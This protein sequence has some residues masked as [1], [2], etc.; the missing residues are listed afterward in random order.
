V[1][2][3]DPI[4]L[5][6]DE[7]PVRAGVERANAQLDSYGRAGTKAN[8]DVG[9]SAEKAAKQ[10]KVLSDNTSV[11]DAKL[12]AYGA[13]HHAVFD[14]FTRDM[15]VFGAGIERAG[16]G[17]GSAITGIRHAATAALEFAAAVGVV[18]KAIEGQA[19]AQ[20]AFESIANRVRAVRIF[21]AGVDG[22]FE[23]AGLVATEIAA[24][25]VIEKVA[26]S[27]YAKAKE[28]EDRALRIAAATPNLSY[29]DLSSRYANSEAIDFISKQIGAPSDLVSRAANRSGG[30]DQL[31]KALQDL[32]QIDDPLERSRQAVVAFGADASKI[33][34][35]LSDRFADSAARVKD[36]G[37]TLDDTERTNIDSFRRAVDSLKDSFTGFGD[38]FDAWS[39]SISLRAETAFAGIFKGI[40]DRVAD[41]SK[42]LFG[43][44]DQAM[45]IPDIGGGTPAG[46]P[47]S[48]FGFKGTPGKRPLGGPGADSY[49]AGAQGATADAALAILN[50]YAGTA[51]K[52]FLD[53]R[54]DK[55]EQLR[56]L[57]ASLGRQLFDQD[58][59]SP[60]FGQLVPGAQ[61][62]GGRV[63]QASAAQLYVSSQQRIQ[64]IEDEKQRTLDLA[65]A[66]KSVDSL[67][68]SAQLAELSGADH[69]RAERDIA[70]QQYGKTKELVQA[71][72]KAFDE[73]F[74][75]EGRAE[76]KATFTYI[77]QQT[78]D[79]ATAENSLFEARSGSQAKQYIEA[80][81]LYQDGLDKRGKLLQEYLSASRDQE[82]HSLDK[83]DADTVSKKIALEDRKFGIEADYLQKS[84]ALEAAGIERQ[85]QRQIASL[86]IL[87]DAKLITQN[88]YDAQIQNMQRNE[89]LDLIL[90]SAKTDAQIADARQKAAE[91][92]AQI[93]EQEN[94]RVFDTF[95][96]EA[97]G[98]FDA[99]FTK[100]QNVFKAIGNIFKTELLTAMKDIVTS[101]IAASL[102]GIVTGS[103]VDLVTQSVGDT[104]IAKFAARL[105]LGAKPHFES[106][107]LDQ[108]NH[109]GDLLLAPNGAVPVVLTNGVGSATAGYI[110]SPSGVRAPSAAAGLLA[111]LGLALPAAAAVPGI[112]SGLGGGG[113]A[114]AGIVSSTIDFGGGATSTGPGSI[115]GAGSILGGPGG[116]T[117]F[118]G[119]VSLGDLPLSSVPSLY[120]VPGVAGGSGGVGGLL[121]SLGGLLKGGGGLSASAL[122]P[123]GL[124][125]SFAGLQ[126]SFHLGQSNS[127]A[128]KALAP[129]LGAV[130]GLLGFGSLSA[131]FPAL[132]A[133]GP[134]GWI[135]AAGIGAAIG[136]SG[137]FIQSDTQKAHDKIK[138]VYGVDVSDKGILNQ[139]VSIAK[140][141]FGDNLDAAI[142]GPQV[143]QLI[144]LYAESTGQNAKGIVA[145]P[146]ASTFSNQNGQLAALPS[147]FDGS[148]VMPGDLQSRAGLPTLINGNWV[149]SNTVSGAN[150]VGANGIP[151]GGSPPSNITVQLDAVSSAAFLQGQTVQ[152]IN[153]NPRS[154]SMASVAGQ[155]AG[156]GARQAAA[157]ALNPAFITS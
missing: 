65:A 111:A 128:G 135:A 141:S 115:F 138:S 27:T 23:A 37:L 88:A 69:L 5:D 57:V 116:T 49:H 114:P 112:F 86:K 96:H 153:S 10:V 29:S 22:G 103:K 32:A 51:Q 74:A 39:Q 133:A 30:I 61:Y 92:S 72:N 52:Q 132:V 17:V 109:L 113:S 98:I 123:L 131:L 4:I 46:W 139:V 142:R 36:W 38:F 18:T 91:K 60:T 58:V 16:R 25:A 136:L 94:Q 154:V 137:L 68:Q 104:P 42:L 122:A 63:A 48:L 78:T 19:T 75:I 47:W 125:G 8:N 54:G 9:S 81:K 15:E 13:T 77:R 62:P 80:D 28:V 93:I 143:R 149:Y 79:R 12:A 53:L 121:G 50:S 14:K 59:T 73:R 2:N 55:E 120:G 117:G 99:L 151:A 130:S 34:P 152:A 44:K 134:V 26:E 126:S 35:I 146:V 108:P 43:P 119:D 84:E 127:I 110:A 102:T 105:G 41:L 140:Q 156:A 145:T 90:L 148:P 95:K 31:A 82:L 11:L 118:A 155:S 147:Y 101:R 106:P 67:V 64:A 144:Q 40:S 124:L 129:V 150:T 87:L 3:I 56:A 71:I 1:T 20:A 85:Y 76:E 66:K 89:D 6:V 21:K 100:S 83:I 97:G 70:I 45:G 107:K 33:L 157:Q 24:V 7:T